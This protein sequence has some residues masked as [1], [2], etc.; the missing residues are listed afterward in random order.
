MILAAARE[1]FAARGL[2]GGRTA[3][4][5]ERAGVNKQ[6]IF[7]YFGSKRGLYNEVVRDAGGMLQR[8]ARHV[9]GDRA[10]ARTPAERIRS[11][12]DDVY[13][14]LD[15]QPALVGLLSRGIE[16]PAPARNSLA[17]FVRDLVGELSAVISEGQGV[18]YLR[19]DREP[20]R[21]AQQ[22]VVLALGYL[23]L[24]TVLAGGRAPERRSDWLDRACDMLIE[25]L[26]W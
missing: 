21:V 17:G 8:G 26:A 25:S 18:G 9:S 13:A 20:Y 5:A 1:E 16:E 22:A 6:L 7:Y 12:L 2:A 10:A 4:I 15:R 3:R 19:D 11:I 14:Q 24:E 23:P